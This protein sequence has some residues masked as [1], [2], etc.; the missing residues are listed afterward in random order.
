MSVEISSSMKMSKVAIPALRI[1]G[2]EQ[3]H[4]KFFRVPL[5]K[6]CKCFGFEN[7]QFDKEKQRENFVEGVSK[8][9]ARFAILACLD[10]SSCEHYHEGYLE[11]QKSVF[12]YTQEG[13]GGGRQI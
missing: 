13:I 8:H 3:H 5:K 10:S 9:K 1:P 2:S 12:L 4:E 7:V 11:L 6:F